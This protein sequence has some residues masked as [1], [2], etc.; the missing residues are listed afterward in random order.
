MTR[1]APS[2][3][4]DR[5]LVLFARVWREQG[6]G[7]VAARRGHRSSAGGAGAVRAEGVLSP[8]DRDP[9]A[10]AGPPPRRPFLRSSPPR[11]QPRTPAL[12]RQRIGRQRIG[13]PLSTPGLRA[14]LGKSRVRGAAAARRPTLGSRDRSTHGRCMRGWSRLRPVARAGLKEA[15]CRCRHRWSDGPGPSVQPPLQPPPLVWW[16]S[17]PRAPPARPPGSGRAMAPRLRL[18]RRARLP[19]NSGGWELGCDARPRPRPDHWSPSCPRARE[20][21]LAGDAGDAGGGP[22]PAGRPPPS[23]PGEAPA[24]AAL[25]RCPGDKEQFLFAGCGRAARAGKLTCVGAR[26]PRRSGRRR[27]EPRRGARCCSAGTHLS[28]AQGASV[29]AD[30]PWIW[31]V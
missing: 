29:S 11:A 16:C 24:L 14:E 21:R 17:Q 19:L 20:G 7:G 26:P 9:L 25:G 3:G 22:R 15:R 2:G 10:A 1:P 23:A 8:A 27:G 4:S 30:I 12:R 13:R 31:R 28:A 18:L 5:Q 6:G